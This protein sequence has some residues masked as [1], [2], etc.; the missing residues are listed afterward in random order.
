MGAVVT[1]VEFIDKDF[2]VRGKKLSIQLW[3]SCALAPRMLV[4]R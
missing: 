3:V 2:V 1:G 4:S